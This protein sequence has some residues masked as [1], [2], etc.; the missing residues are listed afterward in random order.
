VKSFAITAVVTGIAFGIPMGL[1]SGVVLTIARG[2]SFGVSFGLVSSVASGAA[3]GLGMAGFMAF[4]RRR[5]SCARPQF[6]GEQLLHDGPA[7]HFVNGE[8]VGGRLFLTKERVLFRSHGFNIQC[9]ELSVPLAEITQAEP[10][11]TARIFPNGLRLV[12]RTGKEER[13]VV[14]EHRRWCD[15]IF[16]AQASVA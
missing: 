7:N 5:V 10:V 15:E 12:T 9:H 8:G 3:F 16:R 13:F 2:S 11:R 1:L 14:R 6:T 4:F